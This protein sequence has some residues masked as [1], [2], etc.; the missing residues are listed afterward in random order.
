MSA[1]V[2]PAPVLGSSSA[3]GTDDRRTKALNDYRQRLLQHRELDDK[4]KQCMFR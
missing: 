2:A 1:A 3:S 4:L